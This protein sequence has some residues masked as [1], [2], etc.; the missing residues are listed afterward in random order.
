MLW[1]MNYGINQE[2]S[3][4]PQIVC[5]KTLEFYLMCGSEPKGVCFIGKHITILQQVVAQ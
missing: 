3:D 4:M 1:N 2:G 5:H